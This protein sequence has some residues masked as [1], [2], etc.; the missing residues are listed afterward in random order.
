[1]Q[2]PVLKAAVV[3]AALSLLTSSA[4]AAP[5]AKQYQCSLTS[6][7]F[8]TGA[9]IKITKPSKVIVKSGTGSVTFQLKIG[10]ITDAMDA[11]V[12]LANNTFQ[13]DLIR[14]NGMLVTAMFGFDI[15][16]GKVSQKF[17]LANSL[18]PSGALNPGESID[19]RA[20]RLV[21]AGNGNNFAV[22]GLTI[23]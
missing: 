4:M 19:I 10:G 14:P 1:M 6:P 21:Q 9:T 12:T 20:V 11:P 5:A 8:V 18:F 15:T 23:K 17:P 16:N 13:V 2:T 7:P 22:A 3:A